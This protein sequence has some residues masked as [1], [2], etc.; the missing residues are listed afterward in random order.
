MLTCQYTPITIWLSRDHFPCEVVEPRQRVRA[1]QRQ[2]PRSQ[3]LRSLL[4]G[5]A[6][7]VEGRRN[8]RDR[9]EE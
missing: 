2:H 3:Q 1:H 9:E 7:F 5:V 4:G 6:L 8:L